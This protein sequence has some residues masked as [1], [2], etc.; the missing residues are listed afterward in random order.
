MSEAHTVS[1]ALYA[2]EPSSV[3][4]PMTHNEVSVL[5]HTNSR[6]ERKNERIKEREEEEAEQNLNVMFFLLIRK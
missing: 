3:H 5:A 1:C 6:R 2:R 4:R